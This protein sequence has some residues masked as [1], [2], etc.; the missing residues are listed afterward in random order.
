MSDIQVLSIDYSQ[1]MKTFSC[2]QKFKK[3]LWIIQSFRP[4]DY[5]KATRVSYQL[6]LCVRVRV[7]VYS[8]AVPT[9]RHKCAFMCFERSSRTTQLK[10][11]CWRSGV[12]VQSGVQSLKSLTLKSYLTDLKTCDFYLILGDTNTFA[13]GWKVRFSLCEGGGGSGEHVQLHQGSD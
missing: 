2:S 12:R 9:E 6:F 5:S 10:C 3:N 13:L 11:T 7:C 1:T 4:I 8:P